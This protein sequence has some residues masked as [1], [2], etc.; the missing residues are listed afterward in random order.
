MGSKLAAGQMVR[1]IGGRIICIS[2]VDGFTA[3]GNNATYTTATGGI[4]A[5]T[6]SMAVELAPY[7]I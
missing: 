7:N 3:G 6:E 1:Q 2:S 4:N 5:L